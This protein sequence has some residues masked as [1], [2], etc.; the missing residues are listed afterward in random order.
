VNIGCDVVVCCSYRVQSLDYGIAVRV[1][2]FSDKVPVSCCPVVS[3]SSLS[4]ADSSVE[5][6]ILAQFAPIDPD[7]CT[8]V[9]HLKV[10]VN[11]P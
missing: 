11:G 8:L 2:G 5:M 4:S 10:E 7:L 9:P 3:L 1:S 6:G